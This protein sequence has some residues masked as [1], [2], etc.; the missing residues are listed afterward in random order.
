L[1]TGSVRTAEL[2]RYRLGLRHDV[3]THGRWDGHG[4]RRDGQSREVTAQDFADRLQRLEADR[5]LEAFLG[6]FAEDVELR[7]PEQGADEH[8]LDGARRFWQA[9]LD[10]FD[11]IA[12]KF[13]RMVDAERIGELEWT[14]QGSLR[15]GQ[16]ITYAGCSLL[17]HDRDGKVARFATYYDT[18][19]FVHTTV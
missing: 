4:Q 3:L 12:S 10:Q 9:Y 15:T 13:S 11:D 18:A 6:L 14:S 17:E 8:G 2:V 1:R 5:D 19:A 7:R 16:R